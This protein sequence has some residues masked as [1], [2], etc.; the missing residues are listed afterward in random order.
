[1]Q[2]V[3]FRPFVYRLARIHNLAGWVCNT[4]NGVEIQVAGPSASLEIFVRKL[5]ADAPALARIDA[6]QHLEAEPWA[7]RVSASWK[8]KTWPAPR[9]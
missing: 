4:S 6:V 9:P 3:G 8:A 2:G 1:V 5:S 7:R